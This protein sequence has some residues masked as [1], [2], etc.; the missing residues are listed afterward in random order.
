MKA[1]FYSYY[2]FAGIVF[3]LSVVISAKDLKEELE[4]IKKNYHLVT[5]KDIV[6][7]IMHFLL[8]LWAI[9]WPVLFS[10]IVVFFVHYLKY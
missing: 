7:G 3:I 9:F 1:F 6:K 2:I 5:K 4:D 8:L 10:G